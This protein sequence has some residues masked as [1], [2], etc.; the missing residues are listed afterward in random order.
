[1]PQQI[2]RSILTFFALVLV[3]ATI[4]LA[5]LPASTE[6]RAIA[7]PVHS[8]W[9]VAQQAG[10]SKGKLFVVTLDRPQRRQ[11]CHIQSFTQDKLVCSHTIGGPRT[12]LRQQVLALIV[13]GD[14]G[15][16]RWM[17]LG[18]NGA[19]GAAIWGTAVLA[20]ACPACA[21]ATGIAA[22]WFFGA[23][24]ATLICDNQPERLLYL[25]SGQ[26]LPGKLRFVQP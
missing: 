26:E 11:T 25:A 6:I 15:L 20:A 21:V 1:M 13:P 17:V 8:D 18:F 2:I 14:D 10:S 22:L 4:A 5:Q 3:S 7:I 9:Q 24:G 16:K 19:A 23:A 12:Y